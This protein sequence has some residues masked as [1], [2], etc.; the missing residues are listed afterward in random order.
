MSKLCKLAVEVFIHSVKALLQLLLGLGA[1]R[2]VGGVVVDIG[3][4]DSLRESRLDMFSGAAIA[5]TACSNL[6]NTWL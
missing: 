4:E 5:M 2:V 3:K 1:D 6:E